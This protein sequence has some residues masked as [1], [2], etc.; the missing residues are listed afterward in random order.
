MTMT[1]MSID[2]NLPAIPAAAEDLRSSLAASQLTVTLFFAGFAFGQ[3]LWGPISDGTGRRPAILVGILLYIAA[4]IGCAAAWSMDVLL[5][6]RALQGFAAGAGSVLGRAII[7]D[8]FEGEQMAR[9]MSLA[10]AAFVTAP[11]IGPSIGALILTVTSWRGI[12]VFLVVYGAVLFVLAWAFLEESL[13][14]RRPDALKL[15]RLVG[16]YTGV[17]GDRRSVVPA[18]VVVLS[19]GTLTVY[20]TNASALFMATYGMSATEFGVLFAVVALASAA[21][22]LANARLVRHM[23]LRRTI[24]IGIA[25]AALSAVLNLAAANAGITTGWGLVPGFC[26]FFFAFGLIVANGT[27]LALG[28]HGHMAGSATSALGVVQTLIPAIAG[29]IVAALYDGT[30]RPMLLAI[31]L[32]TLASGAVLAMG[33]GR[34]RAAARP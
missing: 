10:L 12:Y 8:W 18:L 2:I 1:A 11:I 25:G 26:L 7:R 15:A 3:A 27:S 5:A 32:L 19:F 31:L 28:P 9:V 22:N 20:L 33:Y 24:A 4:T 6:M 23:T 21:G 30:W 17:F 13:P 14:R 29:S 16:G 34:L